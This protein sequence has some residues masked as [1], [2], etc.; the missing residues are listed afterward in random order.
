M[1]PEIGSKA[2]GFSL[3]NQY[4]KFVSLDEFIGQYVVIW[5][6]PRAFGGNWTKQASGFRDRAQEYSNKNAVSI[7]ITFSSNE[8]L[9]RWSSENNYNVHLLSDSDKKVA[10]SYGVS[11]SLD[12][13][14][15]FRISILV[16]PDGK[17]L[18]TYNVEDAQGHSEA[19]LLDII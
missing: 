19:V 8:E 16:D 2:P 6:Y 1:L 17:I 3:K 11:E 15:P 9:R 13:E 4:G 7:G 18:K 5:F 12:Q 10:L 14:K